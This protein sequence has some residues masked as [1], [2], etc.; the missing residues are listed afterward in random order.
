MFKVFDDVDLDD[1]YYYSGGS[2]DDQSKPENKYKGDM[3]DFKLKVEG[4]I[5]K[6]RCCTD[7]PCLV[8]FWAFMAAMVYATSYGYKNGQYHRLTAPL[9]ASNNFCGFDAYAQYP[10]MMVTDFS[11]HGVGS[12]Y[13]ILKSGVCIKTCPDESNKA[14][15]DGTDCSSNAKVACNA[16]TTYKSIDVFDFCIP[17]GKDALSDAEWAVYEA[18]K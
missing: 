17:A 3:D 7:I 5:E 13:D 16:R 8:L 4:G 14:L 6:N 9:D 15:V 18:A 1:Y 10:K 2:D 12:A 11:V